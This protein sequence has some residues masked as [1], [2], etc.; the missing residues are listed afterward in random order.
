[1]LYSNRNTTLLFCLFLIGVSFSSCKKDFL[2]INPA[3]KL[4][5]QQT[6]DYDLLFN[7]AGTTLSPASQIVLSDEVAA[8]ATYFPSL[9]IGMASLS[10]QKAFMWADDLYLP[11]DNSSEWTLPVRQLYAY[12]KIINEVLNSQG[13]ADTQ[14]KSLQAEALTAR[15]WVYFLLVNYYGKPYNAATASSDPGIPIVL[16]ADVTQTKFTRASVQEVYDQIERDITQALPNLPVKATSSRRVSKATAEA[17][18]GKA[19][20][21]MGQFDKALPLLKASIAD[22]ANAGTQI[23]LYNFNLELA[24]GGAFYPVNPV[25]GP[26]RTNSDVDKEILFLKPALNLYVY[27]FSGMVITPQAA[28]LYQASDLRKQFFT[29]FSFGF[30]S[31]YPLGM[32]RGYGKGYS[33]LG[34]NIPDIYLLSAEC[35]SRMGDLSGAAADMNVFRSNRMPAVDAP[36]PAAIADD[37]VSLTKFI[38]EERIREFAMNGERWFDMRRL[39]VDPQY[40]STVGTT[41][42]IYDDAGNITATYTLKPER[43]VLRFPQY[44]MAANPDLVQNP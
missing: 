8:S 43:L 14:K 37:Q 31:V 41:H 32:L 5:A 9:G 23:G 26:P 4:I 28:A 13:G 36:V 25:I 20:V 44:I 19:Y 2:E 38:L 7:G 15:A 22:L 42:N 10:D 21:Y 40:S 24:P 1:M 6:S 16:T 29:S 33:N 27:L 3:G 39:S 11:S 18:L 12:N 17:I 35:K 30:A 34:V